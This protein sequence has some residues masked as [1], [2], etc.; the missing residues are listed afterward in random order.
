MSQYSV[1]DVT[2]CS[3]APGSASSLLPGAVS[4]RLLL[5]LWRQQQLAGG[6]H[7]VTGQAWF[8]SGFPEAAKRV[9]RK[10]ECSSLGTGGCGEQQ[11]TLMPTPKCVGQLV[12]RHTQDVGSSG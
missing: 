2:I 11:E 10:Q 6:D 1:C 5:A 7:L 3:V 8:A 4:K 12:L 9:P